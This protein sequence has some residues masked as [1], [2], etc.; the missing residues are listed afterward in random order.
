M[1]NTL[2]L[3]PSAYLC[4][5]VDLSAEYAEMRRG[6]QRKVIMAENLK[7]SSTPAVNAPA[8]WAVERL[9]LITTLDWTTIGTLA[10]LV[11]L[12]F[13]LRFTQLDAV[14]FAEDEMNKLDAV[15]S[16]ERGDFTANA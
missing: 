2:S 9:G 15:H 5:E 14:G 7:I 13:G 10:L 3:R 8:A 12:G 16:Y 11:V 4:V 6:P 1:L